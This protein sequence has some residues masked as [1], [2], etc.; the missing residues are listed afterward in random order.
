M[1]RKYIKKE[2]LTRSQLPPIV[3][4]DWDKFT[5]HSFLVRRSD[6]SSGS[7][8]I[9]SVENHV[10][11]VKWV[12]TSVIGQFQITNRYALWNST[13]TQRYTHLEVSDAEVKDSRESGRIYLDPYF[14]GRVFQ[15]K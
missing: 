7:Q 1:P 12:P 2:K 5:K 4:P 13:E 8:C 15:S 14:I 3:D 10:L 11:I 9:W 6:I